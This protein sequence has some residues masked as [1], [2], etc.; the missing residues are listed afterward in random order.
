MYRVCRAFGAAVH[1]K[2]VRGSGVFTVDAPVR[3]SRH[4]AHP[5]ALHVG[6][7]GARAGRVT[8]AHGAAPPGPVRQLRSAAR[9]RARRRR[10]PRAT[11]GRRA[12]EG[13]AA[14]AAQVRLQRGREVRDARDARRAGPAHRR[15]VR[16]Q[17]QR[18]PRHDEGPVRQLRRAEDDRRGRAHAAQG[19]HAQDPAARGIAAQVHV[20]QAHNRETGEILYEGARAGPDRPAGGR[21]LSA[22]AG[23]VCGRDRLMYR[24]GGV[25]T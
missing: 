22:V 7:D 23:A 10:G 15:A 20:R 1:H 18:A 3:L 14:L 24:G 6:A 11:R 2:R 21:A 19:A 12:R 25:P 8:R 13:V 9:A 16:V 17:R 5:G 4:P